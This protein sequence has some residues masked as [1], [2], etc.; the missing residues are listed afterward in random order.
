M[1]SLFNAM[2]NVMSVKNNE[3]S[4]MNNVKML[5]LFTA[6]LIFSIYC[7]DSYMHKLHCTKQALT[8]LNYKS[9]V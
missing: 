2:D 7:G 6:C 8:F 1:N 3:D 5:I 9:S 4:V